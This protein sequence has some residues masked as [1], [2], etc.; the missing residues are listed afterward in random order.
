MVEC[1]LRVERK[2]RREGKVRVE[3]K[4]RMRTGE[5]IKHGEGRVFKHTGSAARTAAVVK[6]NFSIVHAILYVSM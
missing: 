2:P 4:L 1:K 6:R 5:G 3:W